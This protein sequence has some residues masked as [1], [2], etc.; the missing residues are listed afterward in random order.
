[1]RVS[2][3]F[4]GWSNSA[5]DLASEGNGYWSADVPGA[6]V[7]DEYRYILGSLNRWRV[8]PRARDVTNSVGNGVVTGSNYTWKVND[9]G[10]PP[11]NEIVIY[12]M[13]IASYPDNPVPNSTL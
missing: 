7:G 9:F 13:H 1:V 12:E 11:W 8:D 5:N 4:N 3:T 6:G 2:G 10:M